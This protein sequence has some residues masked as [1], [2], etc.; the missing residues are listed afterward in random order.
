ML[1]LPSG[2]RKQTVGGKKIEII[3]EDEDSEFVTEADEEG[4]MVA[5]LNNLPD[6]FSQITGAQI[7]IINDSRRVSSM[8]RIN[9][10]KS[11]LDKP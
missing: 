3:T 4:D 6:S 5:D 2:T 1:N 11:Q 7:S 9:Q 8:V 10:T